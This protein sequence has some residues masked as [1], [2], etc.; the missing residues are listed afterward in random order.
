MAAAGPSIHGGPPAQCS[1]ARICQ[2]MIADGQR[3]IGQRWIKLGS[4]KK[5]E[6]E[7][8]NHRTEMEQIGEEEREGESKD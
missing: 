8:E 7:K 4:K 5:R 2:L 6:E 3:D 1:K